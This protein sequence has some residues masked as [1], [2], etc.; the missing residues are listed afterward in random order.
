MPEI[1]NQQQKLIQFGPF[2]ADLR[3]QEL[4]KQGVRVRLAGQPFQILKMLLE[5]PGELVTR[6]ELRQTLW[7]SDTFVD[8]DHGLSAAVN[9]LR[10]TLCDDADAP[11]YIE[12]LPKR[13]YRFVGAVAPQVPLPPPAMK[14]AAEEVREKQPVKSTGR[15]KLW[16]AGLAG[17]S[18]C[19][20]MAAGFF[21]RTP[22]LDPPKV[23]GYRQLTTDRRAKG[24]P[25]PGASSARI[26]SDGARVFFSEGG[27]GLMQVSANGGEVAAVSNPIP[28]FEVL[29][30]S[31]DKTELLGTSIANPTTADNPLW[32]LS[33]ASGLTRRIGSLN[34]HAAA[35]SPD[36]Q[37]IA[38]A[39]GNKWGPPNDLHIAAKDGSG[40]RIVAHIEGGP[41]AGILWSSDGKRLRFSVAIESAKNAIWEVSSDGGNLHVVRELPE[42]GCCFFVTDATRDGKYL[43]AQVGQAI[44][45]LRETRPRFGSKTSDEVQLT[46]GPI[47]YQNPVLSPDG[48]KIFTIGGRP[49]G[50]LLRYD[51]KSERLEPFLSGISAE[52]L[53][54][55]RDGKWVT[56]VTFPEGTLWRS[57]VDG[58]ERLQL[59]APPLHAVLPRWSPDST[60]IAF[61]GMLAGNNA[62]LYLVSAEGGNPELLSQRQDPEEVDVDATWTADGNSLVFGGSIFNPECKI[63][64]I[65]LRTRQISVVSGSEGMSSPR[66]SPDGRYIYAEMESNHKIF[67]YD[68]QTQTWSELAERLSGSGWPEWSSD[69]KYIYIG[70]DLEPP[71]E[72]FRVYRLRMS[73][74]KIEPMATVK[75][76]GGLVGVWGG[77]MSNAPD[78]SPMLLRDLSIQEIYA[79][80]VEL[81]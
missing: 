57:R 20:A 76:P 17:V 44:W 52:H 31:P 41:I 65:D 54:F 50:E 63:S 2:E 67:L 15:W 10:Q 64:S 7:P 25:C 80:D 19:S 81:P 33:L 4:R 72:S 46:S 34:T 8:F 55:S 9:K 30:I 16:S 56:Y 43:L 21:L 77:W 28:C 47:N 66:V 29:D 36:G 51:L 22:P 79:L 62:K 59:T 3:S 38:F 6:E 39:T 40:E 35:W 53:D 14:V 5:R 71:A 74:G 11:R 78:G 42:N 60:R 13:G 45:A 37:R 27:L 24:Q 23:L 69:G 32:A 75:V 73:D 58:S 1:P 61:S 12:T 70:D 48:K 68:Q 49:R 26:V 18:L